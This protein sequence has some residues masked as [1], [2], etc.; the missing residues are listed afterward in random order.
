MS[1]LA[2]S[3]IQAMGERPGSC[4]SPMIASGTPTSVLKFPGDVPTRNRPDN[5]STIAAFVEVFPTDPVTA[6]TV[7]RYVSTIF[8]AF[9]ARRRTTNDFISIPIRRHFE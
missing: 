8:L 5:T 6:T 9:Q 4:V 1:A 2:N 7:G 3:F